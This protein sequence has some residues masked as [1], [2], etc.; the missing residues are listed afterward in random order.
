M[1]Q[2]VIGA[3]LILSLSVAHAQPP[4]RPNVPGRGQTPVAPRINW[5]QRMREE[6]DKMR[7]AP[8]TMLS[9]FLNALRSGEYEKAASDVLGADNIPWVRALKEKIRRK[10][11]ATLEMMP[12]FDF[13]PNDKF[14]ARVATVLDIRESIL[15]EQM[16]PLLARF[17]TVDLQRDGEFWKIV[18]RP[19]PPVP[20]NATDAVA[21]AR[22]ESDGFINQ[23]A[24][25]LLGEPAPDE[26]ARQERV[27]AARRAR[28]APDTLL[29]HFMNAIN[30]QDLEM[31][32]SDVVGGQNTVWLQ[33]LQQQLQI[34]RP[35]WKIVSTPLWEKN[36]VPDAA[37]KFSARLSTSL[38]PEEVVAGVQTQTLLSRFEQVELVREGEG[39]NV[40]WRIVPNAPVPQPDLRATPE[41]D[42][43]AQ[44][45]EMMSA[46][47]EKMIESGRDERDGL[48]NQ[49]ARVMTQPNELVM[50]QISRTSLSNIKQLGLGILQ[51]V[52]DHDEKYEFDEENFIKS[53]MPYVKN[54]QI[55]QVPSTGETKITHYKI[56]PNLF[57]QNGG[58]IAQPQ[59]TPM[60]YEAG[61]GPHSVD[62]RFGG[63]AAVGFADGHA[64]LITPEQA[65]KLIW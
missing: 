45:T 21:Q 5:E 47:A 13:A 37:D 4:E 60:I 28:R 18:P 26:N 62:Y 9:H 51:F 46:F 44:R 38:R 20:K 65:D 43:P 2:S 29:E 55:F 58:A 54:E 42:T 49:W 64:A 16:M 41:F 1:K 7:R 19:Q 27:E 8:D 22:D 25:L 6:E 34:D 57:G 33:R 17:E 59:N 56:N 14:T 12:L 24:R 30:S 10:P 11:S 31:A 40:Q 48:I 50:N 53:I 52:Q 35:Q 39:E 63:K 15:N 23:W 32:A 61:D 36:S 3:G